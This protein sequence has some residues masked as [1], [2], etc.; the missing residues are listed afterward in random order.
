MI[1]K[2]KHSVQMQK[3]SSQKKQM[4]KQSLSLSIDETNLSFKKASN[5][6]NVL[7]EILNTRED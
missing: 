6:E 5:F 4:H 1:G 3:K 2:A 7:R